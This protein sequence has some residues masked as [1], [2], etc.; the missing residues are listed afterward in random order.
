MIVHTPPHRWQ[1]E[2]SARTVFLAGSIEMGTADDW[3]ARLIARLP[4]DAI[5]LNPR[6]ADWD[7][8]WRQS[9]DEPKFR[10]QVE[11]ELDG[12]ER[13]DVIAMWFAPETKAPITLLEL[14]LFAR[15]GKVIVGCPDGYWRKGNIEVVCA[16]FGCE[17]ATDW[18]AFVTRVLAT[19]GADMKRERKSKTNT[20]LA[21]LDRAIGVWNVTG[22]HP[23]LPGRTLRG[24]VTFERIE[25]G[26][27]VHMHSKMEDPEFPEGGAIFGTDGEDGTCTMLYFD[28]RNVARRYAV[29]LEPDGFTW[30]RDSSQLA[31]RFRV[32]IAE[33]G[34]TMESE[35][36]MKRVKN[37]SGAWEPDLRLSYVRA[38]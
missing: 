4:R 7:A 22:S 20:A 24:R 23:Y 9:I 38:C 29:A 2:P 32:T 36:S 12:L 10:E 37:G 1:A 6:R 19:L 8:S 11:W 34:R 28:E 15:S 27:F 25:G 3:Q 17:L 30:S 5:A 31:Q 26:A 35:G 13:A 16:R 21:P 14:G 18:D 33:D